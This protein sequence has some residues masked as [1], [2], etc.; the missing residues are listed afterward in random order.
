VR[1]EYLVDAQPLNKIQGIPFQ[2]ATIEEK[3]L[4]MLDA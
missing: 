3:I 4:E 2:A 1:A